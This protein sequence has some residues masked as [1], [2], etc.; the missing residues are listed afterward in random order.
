MTELEP[1]M[2]RAILARRGSDEEEAAKAEQR[3]AKVGA[4]IADALDGRT[5]LVGDRFTIADVV[6]G[7]VLDSARHYDVMPDSRHCSRT[8]SGW[9]PARRSSAPTTQSPPEPLP[10][11]TRAGLVQLV[12]CVD[13]LTG[14]KKT[15]IT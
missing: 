2:I 1:A 12:L 15:A 9:T 6:V 8:S 5:Y 4:A 13:D 3:L 10:C 7:G 14:R 11:R